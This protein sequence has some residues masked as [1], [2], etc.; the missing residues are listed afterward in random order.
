MCTDDPGHHTNNG[1][2]TSST[3]H[4]QFLVMVLVSRIS[5]RHAI[6]FPRA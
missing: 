3:L 5:G 6:A 4:V 1:N 2:D